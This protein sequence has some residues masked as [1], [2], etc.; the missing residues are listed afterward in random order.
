M[1]KPERMRGSERMTFLQT[2]AGKKRSV[3]DPKRDSVTNM[4]QVDLDFFES[5]RN[6]LLYKDFFQ[7]TPFFF[8]QIL[9]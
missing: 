1:W 6:K 3:N 5:T 7:S 2:K 9:T 8:N 4:L